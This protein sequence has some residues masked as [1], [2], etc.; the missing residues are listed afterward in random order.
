MLERLR[1]FELRDKG[2]VGAAGVADQPPRLFEVR[3]V[4]D[5][6]DRHHVDAQRK[7]E[8]QVHDVLG[9]DRRRRQCDAGRI[10]PLV[11]AQP[12]AFDEPSIPEAHRAIIVVDVARIADS[13]GWAVPL[14]EYRGERSQLIAYAENKGPEGLERYRA[15]KN[16]ASIDG[17]D[18]L[19]SVAP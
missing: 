14:C 19:R 10:D 12:A 2:E 7:A 1:P 13:C 6:A 15:Q 18:D 9:R 8:R 16:R 3:G 4:L 5:E 17:L 11:L